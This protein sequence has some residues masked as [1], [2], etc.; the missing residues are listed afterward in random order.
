MRILRLTTCAIALL[1]AGTGT[2]SAQWGF[3]AQ[4]GLTYSTVFGGSGNASFRPGLVVGGRV[5]RGMSQVLSF[6]AEVNYAMMGA[7]NITQP[8]HRPSRNSS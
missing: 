2:A 7:N 3:G 4:A 5:E 1:S 8:G 6:S